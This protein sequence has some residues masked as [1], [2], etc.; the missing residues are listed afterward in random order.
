MKTFSQ[1]AWASIAQTIYKDILD[2]DFVK[3]LMSGTLDKSTFEFYIK[4]DKLYLNEF[5]RILTMLSSKLVNEEESNN[6]FNLC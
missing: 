6:F 3:E 2:L 4:Q 1:E 5:R